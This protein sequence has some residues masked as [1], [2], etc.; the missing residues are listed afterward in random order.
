MSRRAVDEQTEQRRAD[1]MM[2]RAIGLASQT[3]PHPNPRVGAVVV[4]GDGIV[5][6]GAHR[7]AGEPHAEILALEQAGEASVGATLFVTLE[8][9]SHHGRTPPCTAAVA[10]A[11]ISRVVV[12]AIDPDERVRGNGIEELRSQG[13]E[14]ITG[15]L[16]DEVEGADAGYFH[17]RR[18]GRPLVTLKL[19]TTLDGQI[20]ASDRTSK[21]ITGEEARLDG[22]RLRAASDVVLVG[23]GTLLGDDPRLDVRIDGYAGSQPRPVVVAGTRPLPATAAI[24]ERDA[25]IYTPRALE[26]DAEQVI[27]GHDGAVDLGAAIKDLGSRGYVDAMVEGGAKLGKALIDGGHVDRIVF[28]LAAKIGAGSGIAAFGGDFKTIGDAV[29]LSIIAVDRVGEDIRVEAKVGV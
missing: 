25:L 23:A 3:Q 20:A 22:H 9:C 1:E 29:S 17:H 21:W 4:S 24:Y 11:G 6:E 28:Y 5:G 15:L 10:K 14:V 8:P 18:T 16:A 7:R 27:V 19:A 12:G 13:I 2:R 26:V